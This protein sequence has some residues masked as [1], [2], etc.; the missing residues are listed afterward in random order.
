MKGRPFTGRKGFPYILLLLVGFPTV[1]ERKNV[2]FAWAFHC[3]AAGRA[4]LCLR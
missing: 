1:V 4:L 3:L 2:M